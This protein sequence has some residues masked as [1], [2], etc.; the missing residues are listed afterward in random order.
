MDTWGCDELQPWLEL[1]LT[2]P[3]K[4]LF[5]VVNGP[6]RG[7]RWSR[8]LRGPT[9]PE[10]RGRPACAVALRRISFA[11]RTPSRWLAKAYR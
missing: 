4:P 9:L 1:R 7:R 3:I 11:T 2:L 5:C 10:R 8:P 6:T